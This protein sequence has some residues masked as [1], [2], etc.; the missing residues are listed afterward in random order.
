MS[1]AVGPANASPR[2]MMPLIGKK[3]KTA[4]NASSS[5]F[6]LPSKIFYPSDAQ[7][8]PAINVS[9]SS[10][11]FLTK[12]PSPGGAVLFNS[13]RPKFPALEE[14]LRP[15][16]FFGPKLLALEEPRRQFPHDSVCTRRF[17]NQIPCSAHVHEAP[18]MIP[19]SV[20]PHV[21]WRCQRFKE[22]DMDN[23]DLALCTKA[24]QVWR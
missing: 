13:F 10:V 2:S 24:I 21:H 22:I 15:V 23:T 18:I 8:P 17:H 19:Y 12:V 16:I 9:S 6:Q 7:S 3:K 20:Q 11:P 4:L 1:Q 14:P 5:S